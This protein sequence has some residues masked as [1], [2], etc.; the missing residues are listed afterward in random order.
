MKKIISESEAAQL[1]SDESHF[2][3]IE[4]GIDLH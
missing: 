2:Q 3:M 1:M 4:W